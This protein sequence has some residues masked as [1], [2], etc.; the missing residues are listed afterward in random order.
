M[1]VP[2]TSTKW[3]VCSQGYFQVTPLRPSVE[4]SV[5]GSPPS[6]IPG[7]EDTEKGFLIILFFKKKK[8]K[9]N[10]K[11]VK[12]YYILVSKQSREMGQIFQ[13]IVLITENAHNY[14]IETV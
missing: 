4:P 1:P 5:G 6:K 10:N 3:S 7:I 8:Q 13:L 11:E 9:T 2:T 14:F 12:F